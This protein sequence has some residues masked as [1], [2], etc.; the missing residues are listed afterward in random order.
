MLGKPIEVTHVT[1]DPKKPA[2]KERKPKEESVDLKPNYD[3]ESVSA[4]NQR[5][6]AERKKLIQQIMQE[7]GNKLQSRHMTKDSVYSL[8]VTEETRNDAPVRQ[9]HH[10]RSAELAL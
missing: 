1:A 2:T 4:M 9:T 8:H 5:R 3:F 10:S 6:Q 7:E